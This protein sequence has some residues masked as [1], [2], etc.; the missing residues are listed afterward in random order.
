MHA[1]HLTRRL[2]L[3]C[4]AATAALA[5]ATACGSDDDDQTAPADAGAGPDAAQMAPSDA[6]LA[7]YTDGEIYEILVAFNEGEITEADTATGQASSVPVQQLAGAFDETYSTVDA[8][9]VQLAKLV[10]LVPAPSDEATSLAATTT[11]DEAIYQSLA[12]AAFDA[13]YL[14]AQ[15]NAHQSMIHLIDT[16]LAPSVTSADLAGLLGT[17][18][19]Q[20]ASNLASALAV[21]SGADAAAPAPDASVDGGVDATLDATDAA[22][23]AAA[24]AADGDDASSDADAAEAADAADADAAED[25]DATDAADG[26]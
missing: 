10:S 17:E 26:D 22:M 21:Q 23:D 8:R 2:G 16:Q 25:A 5:L 7:G 9:L 12:G 20:I 18:R 19:Q 6:T 1:P 4:L 15:I 3:A 14:S 24:D 13:A 11:A